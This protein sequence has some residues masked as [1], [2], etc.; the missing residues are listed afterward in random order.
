MANSAVV[1]EGLFRCPEC[2]AVMPSCASMVSHCQRLH[3]DVYT[4]ARC[5]GELF[6]SRG[7]YQRHCSLRHPNT[8]VCCQCKT[9]FPSGAQLKV[10][11]LAYVKTYTCP[12][13][14]RRE[15]KL[16]ELMH[17]VESTHSVILDQRY[18][19]VDIRPRSAADENRLEKRRSLMRKILSLTVPC[20][21]T[22]RQAG[23]VLETFFVSGRFERSYTCG[24]AS[25]DAYREPFVEPDGTA[26]E[27]DP[28]VVETREENEA[29]AARASLEET[30]ESAISFFDASAEEERPSRPTTP[31]PVFM[32][33]RFL[34]SVL[35][36]TANAADRA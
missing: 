13:C 10:H 9:S 25:E 4:V 32:L 14:G 5:C 36:I 22:N 17:H 19:L 1:P 30:G 6:F 34:D 16:S 7:S 24:F 26:M 3:R 33:K 29:A 8:F 18:V 2:L 31:E 20:C 23:T 35:T 12:M 11:Q 28:A 15:G 21:R 27:A